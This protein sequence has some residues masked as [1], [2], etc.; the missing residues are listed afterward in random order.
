MAK[1]S[2][3][4]NNGLKNLNKQLQEA[5]K[6]VNGIPIKL[7]Q[8][9]TIAKDIAQDTLANADTDINF[10][11]KHFGVVLAQEIKLTSNSKG[12]RFT[13]TAGDN[14]TQEIRYE[15]YYAEYGAGLD[16]THSL[17]SS[18]YQ[19]VGDNRYIKLDNGHYKKDAQGDYW[20]YP[21]AYIGKHKGRKFGRFTNTS[22]P[23][24][25][26]Y[27]ARSWAKK[28]VHTTAKELRTSIRRVGK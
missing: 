16:A 15:L 2:I 9:A 7:E 20:W 19:E 8:I 11:Q 4:A 12:T 13:I 26:M 1:S 5:V 27:N 10:T 6:V 28:K 22:T 3:K 14:A 25:Y 23:I 24:R 17:T 21:D 18:G